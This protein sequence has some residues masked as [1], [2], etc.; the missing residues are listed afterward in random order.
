MNEFCAIY[1]DR[2]IPSKGGR[3]FNNRVSVKHPSVTNWLSASYENS[4]ELDIDELAKNQ[5]QNER[6]T[7][8]SMLD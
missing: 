7:L 1:P 6:S 5:N 2:I 8:T 4:F 3:A